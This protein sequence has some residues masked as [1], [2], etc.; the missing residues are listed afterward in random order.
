MVFL[1]L[2]I[3]YHFSRTN[4]SKFLT[5]KIGK[6]YF[7]WELMSKILGETRYMNIFYRTKSQMSQKKF[8]LALNQLCLWDTLFCQNLKNKKGALKSLKKKVIK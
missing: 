2:G 8:L 6:K 4:Q 1:V 7:H 5:L 3:F